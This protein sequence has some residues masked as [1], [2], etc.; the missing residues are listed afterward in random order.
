MVFKRTEARTCCSVE[1]QR[2]CITAL[3]SQYECVGDETATEIRK[4][5]RA[6]VMGKESTIG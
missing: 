6:A 4:H 2:T 3:W 5:H 1:T